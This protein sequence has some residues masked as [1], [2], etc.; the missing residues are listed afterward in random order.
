MILKGTGGQRSDRRNWSLR[1][2]RPLVI[3]KVMTLTTFADVRTLIAKHLPAHFR[4]KATWRHVAAE[5]DK[6]AT[7]GVA[8]DVSVALRIALSL[9]GVECRP[10]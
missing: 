9:E 4:D 8:V 7:G 5:L 2:P 10:K 6:A 3:P 1:L